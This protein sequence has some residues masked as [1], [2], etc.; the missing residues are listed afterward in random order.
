LD[1]FLLLLLLLLLLMMKLMLMMPFDVPSP[2]CFEENQ[3]FA[4]ESQ[5]F[6]FL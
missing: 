2:A 4:D 3:S 1:G 5:Q 6:V